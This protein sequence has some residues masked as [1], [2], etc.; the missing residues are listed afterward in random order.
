[1]QK[2]VSVHLANTRLEATSNFGLRI[3]VLFSVFGRRDWSCRFL[4]T[5]E[6]LSP[7]RSNLIYFTVMYTFQVL[8]REG[9]VF[10][11]VVGV[12]ESWAA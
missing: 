12:V 5:Y 9:C 8:R 3:L 2:L 11:R 1:M 6:S 10:D 4:Y 7:N